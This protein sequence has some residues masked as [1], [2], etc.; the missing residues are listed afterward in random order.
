M[1]YVLRPLD[2]LYQWQRKVR[3]KFLEVEELNAL[4]DKS[5]YTALSFSN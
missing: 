4:Y 2:I 3:V 1:S 5:E